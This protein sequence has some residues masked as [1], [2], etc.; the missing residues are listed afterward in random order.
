[1]AS[2]ITDTQHI[3]VEWKNKSII[4]H[5][6][7]FRHEIVI[8]N[9]EGLGF[10]IVLSK[11]EWPHGY[12]LVVANGE[13]GWVGICETV[14]SFIREVLLHM[15]WNQRDLSSNSDFW[16]AQ[17]SFFCQFIGFHIQVTSYDIC[18]SLNGLFHLA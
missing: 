18:L 15:H 2:H 16:L 13:S 3:S 9:I 12:Q 11:A 10:Q 8:K 17:V 14:S 5:T 4:Y 6:L 7:N 1:M